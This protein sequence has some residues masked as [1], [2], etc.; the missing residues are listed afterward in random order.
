MA[1]M[2]VASAVSVHVADRGE[3]HIQP[4]QDCGG[5]EVLR[6]LDSG[7][8]GGAFLHVIPE[9]HRIGTA[10]LAT[11]QVSVAAALRGP[12][13]L[14]MPGLVGNLPR[15]RANAPS[16]QPPSGEAHCYLTVAHRLVLLF[17]NAVLNGTTS[18]PG[19]TTRLPRGM[20]SPSASTSPPTGWEAYGTYGATTHGAHHCVR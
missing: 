2:G 18:R 4:S 12:V 13:L 6:C 10:M 7:P 11:A 1:R 9:R 15:A 8:G 17:Q 5:S 3:P 16:R 14:G 19:G 20:L